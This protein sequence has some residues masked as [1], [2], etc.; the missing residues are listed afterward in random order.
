MKIERYQSNQRDGSRWLLGC[1]CLGVISLGAVSSVII[2]FL[3][4]PS[5]RETVLDVVGVE[6]LG[7]TDEILSNPMPTISPLMD[8]QTVGQVT[9]STG[10]YSQTFSGSGEG[11]SVVIGDTQDT[12]QRQMQITFTEAGLL[13]QCRQLSTI[14][15]TSGE[16]VRNASFDLRPSGMVINGEFQLPT[17]QWQSAGMVVQIQSNTTIDIVGVEIGN[18]VFAPT[19]SDF[20]A[21][22]SEAESRG[23]LFLQALVARA[24]VD[25]FSLASVS[26][27]DNSL[28]V[29]MR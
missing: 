19:N 5:L 9:L 10:S 2:A 27:N 13:T 17:G 8:I 26:V 23:N 3:F 4:I 22:I 28:T 21:L 1:G 15:T 18:Q 24:G 16:Q 14:C 11:Y 25:E 20:S 29:I 12:M 7:S 6:A